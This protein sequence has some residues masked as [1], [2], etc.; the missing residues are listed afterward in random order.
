MTCLRPAS[1]CRSIPGWTNCA[2]APT[3]LF[4]D[5][6]VGNKILVFGC[7]NT[8]D[9]STL[10]SQNT[11]VVKVFC[12]GMLPSTLMEYALKKGADGIFITGCRT[13]DCYFRYGNVWLDKRFE[14]NRRPRLRARAD[15]RRIMV[16]RGAET[17]G[18]KINRAL[19]DF[20]KTID[21]LSN[22][23]Q[24]GDSDRRDKE[25]SGERA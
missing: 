4:P 1:T 5:S 12:V 6:A 15:R 2:N 8:F 24:S 10:E 17:D 14:G 7:E 22:R 25:S 16:S 21:E 3:P 13:G 20:Q 19:I 11:A 9:V 18:A 23:H